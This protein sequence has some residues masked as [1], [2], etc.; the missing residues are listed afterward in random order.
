M[1]LVLEFSGNLSPHGCHLF[2]NPLMDG[3]IFCSID[4]I[5]P[6]LAVRS[7]MMHVDYHHESGILC[8]SHDFINTVK[9]CFAYLVIRCTAKLSEPGNRDAHCLESG[10]LYLEECFLG[11]LRITPGGLA[12]NTVVIGI[13]LVS[14]I[15]SYTEYRGEIPGKLSFRKYDF[16]VVI[17]SCSLIDIDILSLSSI[18]QSNR[19]LTG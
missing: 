11:C 19:S 12:C 18:H 3:F 8:I 2:K 15:P 7:V 10:F 16:L 13:E 6:V 9:P 14:Q 5:E 1:S 17:Y 4:D